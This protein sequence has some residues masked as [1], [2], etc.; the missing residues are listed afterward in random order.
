MVHS[1]IEYTDAEKT[2]TSGVHIS[3]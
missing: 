3:E 1:V 2:T